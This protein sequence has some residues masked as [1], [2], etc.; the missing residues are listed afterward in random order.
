MY[1]KTSLRD[2]ITQ[3]TKNHQLIIERK[4]LKFSFRGARR[5]FPDVK[6]DNRKNEIGYSKPS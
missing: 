3:V 6:I 5:D 1:Q 2:L 4:K